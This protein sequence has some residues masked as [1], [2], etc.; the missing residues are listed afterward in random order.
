MA[1]YQNVT[2]VGNVGRDPE[3]RYTGSGV[4]VCSFSVAVTRRWTSRDAQDQKE[5]TVWFRIT[6]WRQLAET[7]SQYVRKGMQILV[8]GTIEASAYLDKDGQPQASLELTADTVQFLGS[9]GDNAGAGSYEGGYGNADE[10][11]DIP[12]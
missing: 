8:V 11:T 9:R 1:G 10:I 7:C 6:A 4:P 12:F 3:L 5:K 2:I